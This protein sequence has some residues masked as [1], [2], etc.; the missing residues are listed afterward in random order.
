[1][2]PSSIMGAEGGNGS[3]W[4]QMLGLCVASAAVAGVTRMMII[5][6]RT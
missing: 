3:G 1:M 6:A 2:P 5:D 4:E